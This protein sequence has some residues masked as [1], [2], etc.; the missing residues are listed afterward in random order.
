MSR[1]SHRCW[2]PRLVTLPNPLLA[3]HPPCT[4]FLWIH[5]QKST[6]EAK[7]N[8]TS[9]YRTEANK[10]VDVKRGRGSQGDLQALKEA[11]AII[12]PIVP[13][14][15]IVSRPFFIWA[16]CLT[17]SEWIYQAITLHKT[18]TYT[19]K[20]KVTIFTTSL[21]KT[22]P[23]SHD[24]QMMSNS[25]TQN[26]ELVGKKLW[27][28]NQLAMKKLV[29]FLFILFWVGTWKSEKTWL[30]VCKHECKLLTESMPL[31]KFHSGCWLNHN[32][33]RI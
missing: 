4:T 14:I 24:T 27:W 1:V 26:K 21:Q 8:N 20:Y 2:R 31:Y 9:A 19:K 11:K 13:N 5:T 29:C 12:S 16:H 33:N 22:F 10:T 28:Y 15:T 7:P 17:P 32:V 23:G 6:R 18:S 30:Q 3:D 25:H